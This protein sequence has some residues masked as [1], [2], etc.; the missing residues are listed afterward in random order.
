MFLNRTFPGQ[1]LNVVL[2]VIAPVSRAVDATKILK[3]EPG[4]KVLK[5]WF[6]KGLL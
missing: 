1:H 5:A 3:I 2:G 4:R 6:I